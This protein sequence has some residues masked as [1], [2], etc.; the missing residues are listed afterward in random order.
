MRCRNEEQLKQWEIAI[1]RLIN[2]T[3]ARRASERYAP[4]RAQQINNSTSPHPHARTEP[5]PSRAPIQVVP[6]QRFRPYDDV[7]YASS[8][9]NVYSN[10]GPQGYPA[11]LGPENEPEDEYEEYPPANGHPRSGRGTPLGTRRLNVPQSVDANEAQYAASRM[12]SHTSSFVVTPTLASRPPPSRM[13]NG[14]NG[15]GY[16]SPPVT[17][18]PQLRSQFSTTK[19][20]PDTVE[21][22][23]KPA[24]APTD[25]LPQSRSRS[26]S[27]PSA[28]VHKSSPPPMPVAP[29]GD[30]SSTRESKRGS[31]SSQSSSDYSGQGSPITPYGSSESSLLR[32]A[33]AAGPSVRVKVHFNEDI[34]MI[35]VS[36]ATEYMELVDK[37]GKKIRL[38]APGRDDVG[39]LRVKYRDEDGDLVSLGST[40]DVQMAFEMLRPG[41]QVTLYVT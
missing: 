30:R 23:P 29:W 34:F 20:R 24:L 5:P 26:I 25:G 27:Q 6:Q 38:C 3:A 36:R 18:R 14:F 37:V 21:G 22:R 2:E 33:A 11:H 32:N 35:T 8:S 31:G 13:V 19:L 28:Y 15:D 1:N 39:P 12:S 9:N 16:T 41:G 7:A 10:G 17:V 40:E 4:S